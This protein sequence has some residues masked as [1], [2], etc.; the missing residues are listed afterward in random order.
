MAR[1]RLI[2][3]EKAIKLV[4]KFGVELTV[5]S[6]D[7]IAHGGFLFKRLNSETGRETLYFLR[8]Y[9]KQE[10]DFKYS[11]HQKTRSGQELIMS[12]LP[13]PDIKK[14]L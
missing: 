2:S 8:R 13:L 10:F 3:K 11:C 12:T 14:Y 6:F 9:F 1:K 4:N 5:A 7:N